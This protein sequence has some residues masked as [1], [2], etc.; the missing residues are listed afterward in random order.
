[1]I[2]VK[3][4]TYRKATA[5]DCSILTKIRMDNM[6]KYM[7]NESHSEKETLRKSIS[8]HFETGIAEG[9]LIT[10]LACDEEKIVSTSG[11]TFFTVTPSITNITGK[12]GYITNMYTYP[13]YRRHGIASK[14]FAL[15]VKE[16]IAQGCGRIVLYKTDMAEN[17]YKNFGF[18]DADG[19]M[20][21]CPN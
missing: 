17:I 16:A 21:Y 5:E 2:N 12:Q 18:E 10:W 11:L 20:T 1:M 3:R 8:N 19:Y 9:S 15:T 13:E 7:K 4:I 6:E 14:L